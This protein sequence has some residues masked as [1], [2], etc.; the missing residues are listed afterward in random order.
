MMGTLRLILFLLVASAGFTACKTVG[1]AGAGRAGSLP[2]QA[3]DFA[4]TAGLTP[5]E[6]GGAR[7]LYQTKCARCHKFYSP[8]AYGE[9]EWR[10]WMTKMSKKAKLNSE[11]EELLSRYLTAFRSGGK[12]EPTEPDR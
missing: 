6:I 11:Q 2:L 1:R 10:S 7:K 4:L 12:G 9:A 3:D 5:D 8:A